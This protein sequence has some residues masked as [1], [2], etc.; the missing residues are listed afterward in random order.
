MDDKQKFT[1]AKKI[2][3]NEKLTFDEEKFVNE[4]MKEVLS[5]CEII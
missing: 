5:K 2:A 3:K 4:Y 1:I